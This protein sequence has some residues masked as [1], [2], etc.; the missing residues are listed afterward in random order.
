MNT[1]T[2]LPRPP[3]IG[4]RVTFN[5]AVLGKLT[6]S[7]WKTLS[8]SKIAVAVYLPGW[9]SHYLFHVENGDIKKAQIR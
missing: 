9:D 8:D 1:A 4:S 5:H 3:S 7:F 6:G 2:N